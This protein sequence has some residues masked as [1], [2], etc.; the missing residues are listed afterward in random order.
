MIRRLWCN[1][2]SI[3]IKLQ[4][5]VFNPLSLRFSWRNFFSQLSWSL[6]NTFGIDVTINIGRLSNN[7]NLMFDMN[8][9]STCKWNEERG[10]FSSVYEADEVLFYWISCWMCTNKLIVVIKFKNN[11]E[12]QPNV[13]AVYVD[14][15]QLMKNF[16]FGKDINFGITVDYITFF[17]GR[18]KYREEGIV[19]GHSTLGDPLS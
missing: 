14:C 10:R 12:S 7:G 18:G 11:F 4:I 9:N 15:V 16:P 3:T 5:R 6:F 2:L 13:Q 8:W 1:P 19:Q 17:L